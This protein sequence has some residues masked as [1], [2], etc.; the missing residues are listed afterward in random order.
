LKFSWKIVPMSRRLS[1]PCSSLGG[2]CASTQNWRVRPLINRTA[3]VESIKSTTTR[4]G[5]TVRCELGENTYAK[6]VKVSDAE[7]AALNIT[8]DAIHPEW[9]YT[10]APRSNQPSI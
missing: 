3:V 2:N 6:G 8:G 10:I 9:N 5:L 1:A 4:T 7:M